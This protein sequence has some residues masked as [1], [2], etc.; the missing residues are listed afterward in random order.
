M[1]GRGGNGESGEVMMKVVRVCRICQARR[2]GF[3]GWYKGGKRI[4]G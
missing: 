1:E 2:G 4:R 3:T